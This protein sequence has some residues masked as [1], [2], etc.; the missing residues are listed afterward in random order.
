MMTMKLLYYDDGMMDAVVY[1]E[2]M[3]IHVYYLHV[4]T[5]AD[6]EPPGFKVH[7]IESLCQ[8]F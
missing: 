8:A 7:F 4:V 1:V 6:Y 2:F 3:I 5:P